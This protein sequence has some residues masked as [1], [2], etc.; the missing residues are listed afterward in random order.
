MIHGFFGSDGHAY[1]R[2]NVYMPRF[3]IWGRVNFLVDTG[4]DVTTLHPSDASNI[5]C[6]FD[7]LENPVEVGGIGG[8]QTYYDEPAIIVFYGTDRTYGFRTNLSVGKPSEET[9]DLES[10]LGLDI[11]NRM[12]MDYDFR[13]KRLRLYEVSPDWQQVLPEGRR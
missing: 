13:R 2:G 1:L 3:G 10:L 5:N 6:P 4:A 12:R 7:E 11:L 8:E 9:D